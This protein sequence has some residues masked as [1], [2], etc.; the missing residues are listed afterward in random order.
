MVLIFA[1]P[2]QTNRGEGAAP[3]RGHVVGGP[4]RADGVAG[5]SWGCEQKIHNQL[6]FIGRN[7]GQD[8]IHIDVHVVM[9][10]AVT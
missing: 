1:N 9:H 4:P 8:L 7:Q 3:T 10:N 2:A 6:F 5:W